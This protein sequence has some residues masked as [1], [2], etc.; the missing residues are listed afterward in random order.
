MLLNG[1]HVLSLLL[2]HNVYNLCCYPLCNCISGHFPTVGLTKSLIWSS[3]C[4]LHGLELRVSHEGSLGD[5]F[6]FVVV[7][8]AACAKQ[9][10]REDLHTYL[11]FAFPFVHFKETGE[12]FVKQEARH[13]SSCCTCLVQLRN[14][15]G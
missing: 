9:S 5:A 1:S 14:I 3:V 10:V 2:V 6:D 12:A 8:A 7:E 13:V 11:V 15:F 4:Y